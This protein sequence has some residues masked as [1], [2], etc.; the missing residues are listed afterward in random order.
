M[1]FKISKAKAK[2]YELVYRLTKDIFADY[3]KH[4]PSYVNRSPALEE[5]KTDVLSDIVENNVLI[6]YYNNE[7]VGSV[8]YSLLEDDIYLLS[9]LGVLADY[10]GLKIGSQL[11]EKVEEE[12]AKNNGKG[13]LLYSAKRAKQVLT[14]YNKLGYEIIDVDKEQE[15]EKA[16]LY[17]EIKK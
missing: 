5:N 16:I 13:I 4:L 17:K 8:R 1:E 9:R 3:S 7:P 2:D 10:R 11:V 14:F 12:V 6:A 15:Y